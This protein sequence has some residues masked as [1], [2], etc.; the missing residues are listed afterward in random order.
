MVDPPTG[1]TATLICVLLEEMYCRRRFKLCEA[2]LPAVSAYETVTGTGEGTG[3]GEA[4]GATAN[5]EEAGFELRPPG[6]L[7]A[8]AP[9]PEHAA[10]IGAM[11]PSMSLDI[12]ARFKNAARYDTC[13]ERLSLKRYSSSVGRR[14]AHYE[15]LARFDAIARN[16]SAGAADISDAPADDSDAQG[17]RL[18]IK[19]RPFRRVRKDDPNM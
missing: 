2:V 7:P 18:K 8:L 15:P 5:V 19:R 16:R 3:A 13:E 12:F 17:R 9:P 14:E 1:V 4:L 11:H 10:R 6:E